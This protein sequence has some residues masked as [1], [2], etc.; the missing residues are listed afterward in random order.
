MVRVEDD[1]LPLSKPLFDAGY[2]AI[3]KNIMPMSIVNQSWAVPLPINGSGWR[4]APP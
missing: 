3:L 2:P 4:K 1:D